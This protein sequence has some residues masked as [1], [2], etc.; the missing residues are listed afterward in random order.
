MIVEPADKTPARCQFWPSDQSAC[1]RPIL[2]ALSV[3]RR[4]LLW[5]CGVHVAEV[6]DQTDR[7][8]ADPHDVSR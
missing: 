2:G 5:L 3:R 8:K 1:L 7:S 6:Y 4:G